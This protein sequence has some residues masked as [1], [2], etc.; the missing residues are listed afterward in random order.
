M[1]VSDLAMNTKS[2]WVKLGMPAV[3][4]GLPALLLVGALTPQ[5]ARASF[6]TPV[7]L[8]EVNV[9]LNIGA[10]PPPRHEV[11]I[12]RNRP[13]RDHV[14]VPGYWAW[15]GGRHEWVE[16]RWERPPHGRKVWVEPKWEH[17]GKGYVFVE[18]Y[19]K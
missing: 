11:I 2:V 6:A 10:P 9:D 12:E 8:A 15:R 14:W 16:G 7:L 19:W 13:S 18:G 17:R 4:L 1:A 5:I 3:S